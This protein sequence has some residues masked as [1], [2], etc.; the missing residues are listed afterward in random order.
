MFETIAHQI[1][2]IQG[3][4]TAALGI[5]TVVGQIIPHFNFGLSRRLQKELT[6]LRSIDDLA[7][8]G[9]SGSS[10]QM[11]KAYMENR[12]NERICWLLF[13]S[14]TND[15]QTKPSNL[16]L[17]IFP[18]AVAILAAVLSIFPVA[19]LVKLAGEPADTQSLPLAYACVVGWL[20]L[21][22]A[23]S[24]L[25]WW[26]IRKDFF[27]ENLSPYFSGDKKADEIEGQEKTQVSY[28]NTLYGNICVSICKA[29][30]WLLVIV[31]AIFFGCWYYQLG[32]KQSPSSVSSCGMVFSFVLIL[33][34]FA[35][36]ACNIRCRKNGEVN[37]S[38]DKVKSVQQQSNKAREE[39][40]GC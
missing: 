17:S 9:S 33:V 36:S 5:V 27:K 21:V 16:G 22:V 6:K 8:E 25:Y 7:V 2:T 35:V 18:C 32:E 39:R 30:S 20:F 40:S 23:F 3:L 24:A 19:A 29:V 10:S 4:L 28:F 38:C 31:F 11:A 37:P 14:D 12:V 34:C 26:A 13:A 1:M 15:L